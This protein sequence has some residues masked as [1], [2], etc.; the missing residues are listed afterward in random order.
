MSILLQLEFSPTH[1]MLSSVILLR[2]SVAQWID[3]L[4]GRKEVQWNQQTLFNVINEMRGN[5]RCRIKKGK[6]PLMTSR[7]FVTQSHQM[8]SRERFEEEKDN[9]CIDWDAKQIDLQELFGRDQELE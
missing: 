7:K 5:H 2:G 4:P 3:F 6:L 1:S 8:L 9:G